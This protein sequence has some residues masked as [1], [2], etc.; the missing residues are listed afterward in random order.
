MK[1]IL[2]FLLLIQFVWF[3]GEAI[4]AEFDNLG[5][6]GAQFLKI[7]V[8]ARVV[9][10]GGAN[11]AFSKGAMALYYNP[12]GIANMEKRSLAFSYTDWVSDIKY[13]YFAYETPVQGFGNVGVHVGVLTMGDMEVTTTDLPEG[14]GETFGVNGWVVGISNAYQLTNRFSFGIT[15]K[16][17]REQISDLSS[18]ALAFDFGTLYYTGF[19][20]LRIAM[21]TRNFGTDTKFDGKEL[22]TTFDEDNNPSTAPIIIRK[23]TQSQPLPL[24]FRLG[25]AYDFEFNEQSKLMAVLDGYNTRD[26]GQQASLGLEYSWRDQLAVRAGYKMR[27][28][29]EGLALGAGYD[30]DI[31]RFGIIGINYAWADFGRLQNSH[32]FSLM[33]NF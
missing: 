10:L 30:F 19:R 22:E 9:A 15:A 16:Y 4:S 33:I 23:K 32:R 1:K 6:A 20:T 8:D 7:D 14:T 29:E 25:V 27:T 28:D 2:I 24:M 3:A 18:N 17:I 31:P 13:N 5:T 26:R 11:V 21:S 12:A